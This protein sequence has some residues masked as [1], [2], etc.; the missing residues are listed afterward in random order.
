MTDAPADE[1]YGGL[2]LQQQQRRWRAAESPF[3]SGWRA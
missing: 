1:F 2:L 3:F